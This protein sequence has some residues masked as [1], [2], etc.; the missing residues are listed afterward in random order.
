MVSPFGHD[1]S[2]S[3]PFRYRTKELDEIPG[4]DRDRD[5]FAPL[6]WTP[7]TAPGAIE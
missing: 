2:G 5:A 4:I 3:Q 7:H 6:F 1:L